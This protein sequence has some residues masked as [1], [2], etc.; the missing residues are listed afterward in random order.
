MVLTTRLCPGSQALAAA[1]AMAQEVSFS[2]ISLSK[3]TK[4]LGYST[5]ISNPSEDDIFENANH[6]AGPRY[7]RDHQ[8]RRSLSLERIKSE[9]EMMLIQAK[10]FR[11]FENFFIAIDALE[12]WK[13]IADESMK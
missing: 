8:R 1:K 5:D 12:E 4:I 9:E 2:T 13:E 7:T 11:D 3:T 6:F 10:S